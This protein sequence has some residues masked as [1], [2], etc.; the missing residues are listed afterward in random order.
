MRGA[1]PVLGPVRA[2][3][4]PSP[5][6]AASTRGHSSQGRATPSAQLPLLPVVSL[7]LP[8]RGREEAWLPTGVDCRYLDNVAVEVPQHSLL[9]SGELF[10]PSSRLCLDMDDKPE[11]LGKVRSHTLI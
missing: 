4:P 9:A 5:R 10:N 8:A 7:T 3:G 6:P 1:V 2:L 11:N